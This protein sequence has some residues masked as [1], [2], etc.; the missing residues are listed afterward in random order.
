[1]TAATFDHPEIDDQPTAEPSQKLDTGVNDEPTPATSTSGGDPPH[2]ALIKEAQHKYDTKIYDALNGIRIQKEAIKA[3]DIAWFLLTCGVLKILLIVLHSYTYSANLPFYDPVFGFLLPP[4]FALLSVVLPFVL[5]DFVL[6]H[7]WGST[8]WHKVGLVVGALLYV[9]VV[10][11]EFSNFNEHLY[12]VIMN[13][14]ENILEGDELIE[15]KA[16]AKYLANLMS[17]AITAATAFFTFFIATK[18]VDLIS[19]PV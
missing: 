6:L 3:T 18:H 15:A 19:K 7:R 5:F 10:C 17:V 13:G 8:H 12:A 14:D 2:K 4:V 11:F 9:F 16:S 1:M